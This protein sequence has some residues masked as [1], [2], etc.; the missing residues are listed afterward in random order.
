MARLFMPGPFTHARA[1]VAELAG[2]LNGQRLLDFEKGEVES[3]E[4]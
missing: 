1:A 4:K 2:D 3:Q